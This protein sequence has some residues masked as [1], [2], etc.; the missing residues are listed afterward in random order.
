MRLQ[1]PVTSMAWYWMLNVASWESWFFNK[2]ITIMLLALTSVEVGLRSC[3][4]RLPT[5]QKSELAKLNFQWSGMSPQLPPDHHAFLWLANDSPAPFPCLHDCTGRRIHRTWV[6]TC[7]ICSG[8]YV[9][10][11]AESTKLCQ[12]VLSVRQAKLYSTPAGDTKTSK[13]TR[14]NNLIWGHPWMWWSFGATLH[15]PF[16]AKPSHCNLSLFVFL[17]SS[18]LLHWHLALMA[19]W[20]LQF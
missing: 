10:V 19:E 14:F 3:G 16:S 12:Q 18:V 8:V 7:R 9:C 15:F 11:G 4:P 6:A 17:V 2:N 20:C 13:I 1:R 5:S